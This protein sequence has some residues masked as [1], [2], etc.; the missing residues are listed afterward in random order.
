MHQP[1]CGI[2]SFDS[3]NYFSEEQ[4]KCLLLACAGGLSSFPELSSQV[5]PYNSDQLLM[6]H[7]IV[8][9]MEIDNNYE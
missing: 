9:V 7:Q 3:F 5:E 8:K 6:V 2:F 1:K 4:I